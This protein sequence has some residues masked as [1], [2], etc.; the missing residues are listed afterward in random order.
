[1]KKR[2]NFAIVSTAED[3]GN[4]KFTSINP[5]LKGSSPCFHKIFL[6]CLVTRVINSLFVKTYF[7]PDEHWQTLEVA[8]RITF[9]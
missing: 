2:K 1:M 5:D 4:K 3:D 8:H 7:N 9:G 6:L